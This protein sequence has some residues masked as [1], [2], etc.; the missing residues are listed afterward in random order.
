MLACVARTIVER[1]DARD[2][3]VYTDPR[4]AII[5]VG[6]RLLPPLTQWGSAARSFNALSSHDGRK[7]FA[8]AT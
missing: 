2:A 6:G 5:T 7:Q 3:K 8:D 4:V 1:C